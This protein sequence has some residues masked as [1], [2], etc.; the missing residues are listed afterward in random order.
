MI[1]SAMEPGI[2]QGLV[3]VGAI[4]AIA[5]LLYVGYAVLERVAEPIISFLTDA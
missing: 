4:L 5:V 1:E 2:L 3:F